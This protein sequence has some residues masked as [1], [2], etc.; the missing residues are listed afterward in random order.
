MCYLCSK[1]DDGKL[2]TVEH[3]QIGSKL[4]LCLDCSLFVKTTEGISYEEKEFRHANK[5]F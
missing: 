4:T 2:M 1:L 5:D 3:T